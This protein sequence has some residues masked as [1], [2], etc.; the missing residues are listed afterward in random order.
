MMIAAGIILLIRIRAFNALQLLLVYFF[1]VYLLIGMGSNYTTALKMITGII[2]FYFFVNVI[3]PEDF[4]NHIMAFSLGVIGSSFIGTFRDSLPQLSAYFKTEYTVYS[5]THFAYR[6][7]G[8][9]YD[10]N[11]YSMSVVFALVLCMMLLM[12]KIGSKLLMWS[13]LV[14]LMVFGLQSY[15]KMFLLSVTI[16]GV[17]LIMYVMRSLKMIIA[18]LT[19]LLTLGSGIIAWLKQIGYMDIMFNRLFDGDISTGRFG[20]WKSYL[21]YLDSSPWTLC[22]GDGIGAAYLSIGGPHNTYIESIFFIGILGSIICVFLI[23]SIFQCKKYNNKKKKI[24]NY[25]LPFVFLTIIGVLG[26]FTINELFFYC[27]LIWLGL[28]IDIVNKHEYVRER[29]AKNV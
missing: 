4:K 22:F 12:N 18:T 25:L 13:L 14:S 20:I 26:C 2:L 27:M 15:S 10:P 5:G 3:K 21:D 1:S 17:I 7:T 8:L 23:I 29:E 9:F 6:F 11:F 24:I 28:N 16:I 19:A